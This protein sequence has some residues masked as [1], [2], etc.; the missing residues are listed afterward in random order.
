MSS[1]ADQFIQVPI[2]EI[3][4]L[5]ESRVLLYEFLENKLDS[6]EMSEL[7]GITSQIWKVSNTV[8]WTTYQTQ[9]TKN[10]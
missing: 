3:E 10:V 5:E 4:K 2:K 7:V 9:E 6:H 8:R 1:K